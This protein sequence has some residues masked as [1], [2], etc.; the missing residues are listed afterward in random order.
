MNDY[1]NDLVNKIMNEKDNPDVW[2][3]DFSD[4]TYE[5]QDI[6]LSMILDKA[7]EE[8]D[9]RYSNILDEHNIILSDNSYIRIR[10]AA[11]VGLSEINHCLDLDYFIYII[12]LLDFIDEYLD[13]YVY[14]A[15]YIGFDMEGTDITEQL[16]NVLENL[17]SLN[18]SKK[19]IYINQYK[20][21]MIS[22]YY[23][24]MIEEDTKQEIE[25]YK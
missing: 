7:V 19:D 5:E 16:K 1:L 10:Q 24:G 22:K 4:L 14:R 8:E 25:K 6:V 11:Q 15:N 23:T 12:K 2:S 3:D 17:S 13:G 20:L 18:I 21:Y 9:A